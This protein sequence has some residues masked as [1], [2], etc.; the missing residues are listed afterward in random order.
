MSNK[1]IRIAFKILILSSGM[2]ENQ[3]TFH[4]VMTYRF[5]G[6]VTD[7]VAG[8]RPDFRY[9]VVRS[10][11]LLVDYVSH[12]SICRIFDDILISQACTINRSMR[13]CSCRPACAQF[14]R[15]HVMV[16]VFQMLSR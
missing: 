8:I 10:C 11:D 13:C 4:V 14:I 1:A 16:D 2:H 3:F 15:L 7:V 5:V 9:C 6:V 12:N